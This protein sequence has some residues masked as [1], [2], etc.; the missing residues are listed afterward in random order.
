ML[1][2]RLAGHYY[3]ADFTPEQAMAMIEDMVGDLA[4]YSLHDVQA[5]I[6]ACRCNPKVRFF[7]SSGVLCEAID[8]IVRD[9]RASIRRGPMAAPGERPSIFEFGDS[10]PLAWE[11]Q[12]KRFWKSHWR[13]SD[14][15]RARDPHRRAEYDRW[16]TRV[17]AGLVPTKSPNDY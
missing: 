7:P 12:P 13:A 6:S 1:L 8:E 10:R 5:G 4:R 17:K 3:R 15:D 9:R 16:L 2:V 11:Y 14:L